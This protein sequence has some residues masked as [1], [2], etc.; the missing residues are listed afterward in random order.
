[1]AMSFHRFGKVVIAGIVSI[2]FV[3][4][5]PQAIARNGVCSNN[6]SAQTGCVAYENENFEG[7]RQDLGP[8]RIYNYVGDRMNDAISSFRVAPGCRIIA[9]EHRDRG[10]ASTEFGGDCQYV[11]DGW[12]DRISSWECR[13]TGR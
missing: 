1:M 4:F 7:K 6:T 5:E 13:C 10:G 3:S 9:W 11:G 8:N 12:N 2:G